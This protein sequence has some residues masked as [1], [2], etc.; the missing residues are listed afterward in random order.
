MFQFCEEGALKA[1]LG[2]NLDLLAMLQ[3]TAL[4]LKKPA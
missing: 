3:A 2:L 1:A 4:G